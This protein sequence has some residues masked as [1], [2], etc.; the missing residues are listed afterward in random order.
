[1]DLEPLFRAVYD[2]LADDSRKLVLADALQAAGDP[3]GDFITFQLR[4]SVVTRR[5]S[6]KLLARHRDAFLGSLSTVVVNPT[7]AKTV[8]ERWEKGFLTECTVRLSGEAVDCLEWATVQT[9]HVFESPGSPA[10]LA[11][12]HFTSLRAVFLYGSDQ[13]AAAARTLLASIGDRTLRV[14]H[15]WR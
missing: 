3:R 1:M 10:E 13:F 4:D 7:K 12:P 15:V 2:D 9:L 6:A 14:T 8:D 11:S 5:R